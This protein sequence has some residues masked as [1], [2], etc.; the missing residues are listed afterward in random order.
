M[1]D[2]PIDQGNTSA[3]CGRWCAGQVALVTGASSGIGYAV[4]LALGQHGA[5]VAINYR[6]NVR[7]AEAA[8]RQI[9]ATGGEAVVVQGDL[10]QENDVRRVFDT[11][12][13]RYGE[14]PRLLVNNAGAWMKE[15][16]LVDCT[17][18][19]WNQMF[20]I[21]A[22]SAFLCC[23]E[24]ARRMILLGGGAIVNVGS[25]AGHTGG[26]GGT[27][28][29]AAAKAAVHALTR[30][31]ARELAPYRIRV[32]A[33]AP[34]MI[35]TPMLHDVRDRLERLIRATP[36]ARLGSPAEVAAIIVM[37]LSPAASYLTGEI[38][39]INGGLLMR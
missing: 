10:T 20:D 24:A 11:V 31:L 29:Y 9:M 18:E 34:G 2:R 16:P 21:N 3:D 32:N 36:L 19:H 28:P 6:R 25:I 17:S 13:E 12:S 30:G 39:E 1:N 8:D 5:K 4:A 37:L 26:G 7:E 27:V 33:V 35:D 15:T 22:K 38:V 23:R 14:A